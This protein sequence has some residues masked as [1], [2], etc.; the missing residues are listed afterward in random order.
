M[1]PYHNEDHNGTVQHYC[2]FN[3][4]AVMAT[5]QRLLI[6]V[7]SRQK[8]SMIETEG[9]PILNKKKGDRPLEK[10]KIRNSE[11]LSNSKQIS[12]EQ[13]AA[14]VLALKALA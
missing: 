3:S 4:F 12:S 10:D 13:F 14:V 6:R 2:N 5:K 7:A 9:N 11:D 8:V 1:V